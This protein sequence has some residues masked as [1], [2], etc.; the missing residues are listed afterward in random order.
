MINAQQSMPRA[1]AIEISAEN[2]TIDET[3]SLGRGL[4]LAAGDYVRVSVADRGSGIP[5]DNLDKIFDPFFS[6]KQGGS[7]LGL[8][9]SF[10]IARQHGG[11]LSVESEPGSGSTFFLYLPTANEI[12]PATQHKKKATMAK[13]SARLMLMDDDQGVREIAGKMLANLG[14]KDIRFAAEGAAA[15]KRYR[16]AM[17]SVKPFSVVILDLTIPGGIGGRETV[18]KLFEIDPGVKAL[19]SSGYAD[20]SII[21]NYKEHGFSGIVIKPYTLK[22]LGKAVHDLTG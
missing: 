21:A 17:E 6:P 7:E 18:G 12:I 10:S 3:Q 13:G 16:A 14:Y 2:T 8:A 5:S 1:G 11:Y 15:I 4:P 22:E 19:V 9:T 20:D